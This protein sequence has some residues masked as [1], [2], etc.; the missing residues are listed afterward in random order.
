MVNNLP[1]PHEDVRILD[2]VPTGATYV[3]GGDAPPEDDIVR[4]TLPV[5][6]PDATA[7]VQFTVKAATTLVNSEYS[8]RS[9]L[10]TAFRGTRVVVTEIDNLP[11]PPGGD[12]IALTNQGALVHWTHE[13]IDYELRTNGVRN[14]KYDIFLPVIANR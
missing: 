10:T 13:G 1:I 9:N 4:W 5:L 11:P 12:G 6:G 2:R 8:V 14:P 3:S 7:E